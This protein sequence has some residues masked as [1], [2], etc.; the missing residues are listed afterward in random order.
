MANTILTIQMITREALRLLHNNL[1]FSRSVNRQYNDQFAKG[2][3]KI[4][5]SLQIR[6]P[7]RYT[8]RTGSA[9]SVNDTTERQTTLTVATQKGV[10]VDFT[11]AELT[12]EMDDFSE[13]ILKPAMARVASQIDFDGLAEY[14]NIYNSVGIGGV[15]PATAK[16]FLDG[17]AKMDHMATPRDGMRY[18]CLNPNAQAGIVD[19]LK[20]LFQDSSLVAEQYRNGQMGKGLGFDFGMDQN[21]NVHTV[22]NHAG[23]TPLVFG[24]GQVGTTVSTDGWAAGTTG[25]LKQGDIITFAGVNS[26]N[27]ET[28]Q[29]TGELAQFN[30]LF[31][32]SAD[33]FGAAVIPLSPLIQ[34]IGP[35][36][37]VTNAPDDN[38]VITVLGTSEGS[39]PMNMLHHRDAFVLATADLEVPQGVDF[40]S[41]DVYDGISMRIVRQYD[42]NT[43]KFPCRIDVLYGWKTVRP[44]YACRVIG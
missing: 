3:A 38:A 10:D 40:A 33:P 34:P 8:V 44:E 7:N 32:V 29:D 2:G 6:L 12:M 13:R 18:A 5:N 11:S 15:T 30:V 4:G 27:P 17:G 43:D 25:V 23:S 42:I 21:I 35:L 24:A 16:V 31:D 9:I 26:V 20:G 41:R 37:T 19:G 22:G 28:G 36:K 14:K 39:H 1:A